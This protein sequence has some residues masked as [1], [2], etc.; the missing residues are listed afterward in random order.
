MICQKHEQ[1]DWLKCTHQVVPQQL[2]DQ[3][4]VLVAFF[5]QSVELSNGIVKSLLCKVASLV[6]RVEDLI[7]EDGEVQGK[8]KSDR[9]SRSEIGL[10]N[11]SGGLVSFKRLV[12]G[13]LSLIGGCEFGEVAVVITLPGRVVRW[14][15]ESK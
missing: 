6:G 2:H 15:W 13:L 14:P 4:R 12:G 11:L 5:A 7:V 9:V 3:C 1:F 8:T 10:S